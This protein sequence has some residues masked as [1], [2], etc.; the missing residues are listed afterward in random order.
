MIPDM[1]NC[2]QPVFLKDN[3][4]QVEEQ[5]ALRCKLARFATRHSTVRLV[6]YKSNESIAMWGHQK[7]AIRS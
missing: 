3:T 6:V 7:V 5:I 1:G 4:K 2:V